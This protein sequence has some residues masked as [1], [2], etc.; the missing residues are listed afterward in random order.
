MAPA[1]NVFNEVDLA[2]WSLGI[3]GSLGKLQFAVGINHQSGDADEVTLRNLLSGG[4]IR[5]PVDI[6]LTGFIY[7]VSYQF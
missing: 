2:T 7:S 4:V 5:S 6:N 3:S 1:D